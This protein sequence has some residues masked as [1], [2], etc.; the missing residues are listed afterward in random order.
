M[1]IMPTRTATMSCR[2][3]RYKSAT[4][5]CRSERYD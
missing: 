3:L 1:A 5:T 2:L 4:M